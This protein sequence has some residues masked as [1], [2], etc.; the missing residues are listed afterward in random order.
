MEFYNG[1]EMRNL[2]MSLLNGE[3]PD[4]C[5]SCYYEDDFGKLSGRQRQLI[6]SGIRP[7]DFNLSFR[8]S[9]HYEEFLHSY[10]NNGH[11]NHKPTDLQI[12]LGNTC[13]SACIMCGP[14]AS[15]RLAQDYIKLHKINPGL[16]KQS[17]PFTPWTKD[18]VR[19]N[20][21]LEEI[22]SIPD[23][24][25]IHFLGGETLYDPAFYDICNKLIES[26][27][28]K[29]IIVGTTT[30]GTIYNDQLKDL[31]KEFKEFHLGISIE[32]VSPLNNYIR[33][34]SKIE[35][36]LDNI[37][38]FI[39]L[40]SQTNLFISLRITPN[41]FTVNEIDQLFEFMIE[42]DL[43]AESCNTLNEP[44]CLR[45]EL[46]PD[47]IRKHI[48][49]KLETLISKYNINKKEDLLNIRRR[50]N[51]QQGIANTIIDYYNIVSTYT[52]P[53][54]MEESRHELVQFLKS[55]ELIRNN[56]IIDFAPEYEEFLRSY[57]Y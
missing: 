50:D 25:Y 19:L 37:N 16:F 24:K 40:R 10:T 56:S 20:K 2:R 42:N 1:D 51:I 31:I 34:P 46:L 47:S 23:I 30:N 9:P 44:R 27:I 41:I 33:Y 4:L 21:F 8:S 12:E 22:K 11:S 43:I 54:D 26:G 57:G 39:E 3:N 29:N 36:V 53:D 32:S 7:D 49:H 17:D 14:Y 55:F 18:P 5:K 38:K 48:L 35:S 6:K 28:S 52:S 45:I 13:N 15:S